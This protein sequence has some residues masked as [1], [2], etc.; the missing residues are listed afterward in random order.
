MTTSSD[1]DLVAYGTL[2]EGLHI[3]GYSFERAFGQLESLLID[4]RWKL[5]G[6]FGDINAFLE[7]IKLDTLKASAESRKRF[8][9]RIRQL[10]P[11]A[12]NR[13]IAKTLGVDEKTVR[14]DGAA[15]AADGRKNTSQ[16]NDQLGKGAANAARLASGGEAAKIVERRTTSI[17]ETQARRAEREHTR[18]AKITALPDQRFGVILADPGWHDATWSDETGTNRHA[19]K[20]YAT[21]SDE[22]I[23]AL[24]VA[25]IAADDCV[26][27]L[28]TTNQHLHVA[29]DTM[30]AW[31][32]K[33]RSSYIWVKPGPP[34]TG[35]WGRSRHEQLL[36][37]T[38]GRPPCPAPG[39]QWETII[40]AACGEHSAKPETFLEMIEQYF[41][42]LPK[43]ELNRRG[44]P[45]PRWSAWGNEVE[46]IQP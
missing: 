26:L 17:E 33:Y 27:F 46:E 3:A 1:D 36:I 4:D 14:R 5:G 43:I 19:S 32:F 6:R 18:G 28:W 37:G 41:P 21:S 30:R 25:S 29:I 12:S 23:Q 39:T 15:N 10:Q 13:A 2:C 35:R 9:N 42:T 34:S 16:N 24:P 20:H 31:G 7:S 22:E 40:E 11:E 38:C 8:T 44:P 45:R